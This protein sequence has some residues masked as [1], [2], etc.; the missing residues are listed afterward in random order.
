MKTMV[1]ILSVLCILAVP[2]IGQD[3]G[4]ETPMNRN[5]QNK[6]ASDRVYY[7]GSIGL[8]IGTYFRVAVSPL[9]GYRVTPKFSVGGKIGYEYI[10]DNRYSDTLVSSNYG[11]SVFTRY[12]MF[13]NAFAHAEFAYLSYQYRI[14]ENRSERSWIPFLLL[15]GGY[16]QPL[17]ARTSLVIQV[18]VDVLQHENS[19]YKDWD[20][21]VTLGVEVGL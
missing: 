1:F 19:P 5:E 3:D 16:I 18:L 9:I 10:R 13:P 11:G 14:S 20:P 8:S 6:P 7:G 21:V 12:R 2:L 15:G 17:S 4:M